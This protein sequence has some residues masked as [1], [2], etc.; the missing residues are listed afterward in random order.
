MKIN[1]IQLACRNENFSKTSANMSPAIFLFTNPADALINGK[2]MNI[3]SNCAVLFSGGQ[4]ILKKSGL[5]NLRF[6]HISFRTSAAD[7]Q[8]IASLEIPTD[9]PIK[10][11]NDFII[12]SAIKSMKIHSSVKSQLS[13]EFAELSMRIIFIS[14]SE[15]CHIS[16]KEETVNVPHF[17][18]LKKL[19]DHIYENP[20]ETLSIAQICSDM[21]I[22]PT[23]LHRL[24]YAAFGVTCRQDSIESRLIYAAELLESTDLTIN[25]I[26]DICGYENDSYFMR[27]FKQR[28]GCTPTE[29]RKK[30]NT[31]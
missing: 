13:G 31:D 11:E 18:S 5:K 27:Q 15:A 29:Y 7:R 3:Q 16:D 26:S 9:V 12:K 10:I 1:K 24:Y 8:Y 22:S 4:I 19:R 28:R 2:T 23:Y 25:E 30:L 17:E 6:D 20:T 14:L 21:N